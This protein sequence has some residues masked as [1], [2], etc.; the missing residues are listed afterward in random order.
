MLGPPAFY[1]QPSFP[2]RATFYYPWFPEVWT[3]GGAHV[4]Y[5]PELGYYS[6]DDAAVQRAHIEAMTDAGLDAA[7]ASWWGFPNARDTRFAQLLDQTVSLGSPLKWAAYQEGEGRADPTP[8]EIAV[9]LEHLLELARSPAYLRVDGRFVVFVYNA[10]NTDGCAVA[11]RWEQA[12]ALI[13]DKAYISLLIFPGY[14]TCPTQPDTWHQ[15]APAHAYDQ[16]PGYTYMISPG[17]W[18]ADEA[19]PRLERDLDRWR[20][21]VADMVASGEP[22]QLIV[23]FNEWGEGTAVEASEEW[24]T[25]Y[26]DVL[27][28]ALVPVP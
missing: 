19:Q 24:G 22:W 23:S 26:L 7:I 5:H 25:S 14:R 11:D 4:S 12:N 16:R 18:R 3:V 17:F 21:N 2:I 9:D 8:A 1:A 27:A 15:Y 10:D 28:E 20:Q 13:G 6:S